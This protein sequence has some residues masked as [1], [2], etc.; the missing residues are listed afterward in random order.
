MNQKFKEYYYQTLGVASIV[1][2]IKNNFKKIAYECY[3]KICCHE[4]EIKLL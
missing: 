2:F 1:N 3:L 4:V